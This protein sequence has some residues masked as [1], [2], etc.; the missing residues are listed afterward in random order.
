MME[1]LTEMP[2]SVRYDFFMSVLGILICYFVYTNNHVYSDFFLRFLFLLLGVSCL[3]YGILEMKKNYQAQK[4]IEQKENTY[5]EQKIM[6][7]IILL[8]AE[9]KKA[10][11]VS[12]Q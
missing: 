5:K 10:K 12:D 9:F 4:K 3:L 11:I 2:R 6:L 1:K 7:D 8:E